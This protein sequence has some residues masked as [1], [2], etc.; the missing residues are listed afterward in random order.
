MTHSKNSPPPPPP[1]G[2]SSGRPA[3]ASASSEHDAGEAPEKKPWSRPTFYV[4]TD[5]I[6]SHGSPTGK[7]H[8]PFGTPVRENES[9]GPTATSRFKAYRPATA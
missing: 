8:H 1:D 2:A 9:L 3:V 6:E 7:T 4:L 5:V